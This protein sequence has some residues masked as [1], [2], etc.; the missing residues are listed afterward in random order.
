MWSRYSLPISNLYSLNCFATIVS[1]LNSITFTHPPL[2]LI[3][4]TITISINN[5]SSQD[6]Q[7]A[8]HCASS[9]GH[10][11][12]VKL[13]VDSGAQCDNKDKVS[14][15]PSVVLNHDSSLTISIF[16]HHSLFHV[17]PLPC[18]SCVSYCLLVMAS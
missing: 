5:V 18:R 3:H 6:G 15:E 12:V 1:C 14:T 10:N 9:T 16:R 11:D 2:S 4:I 8:L 13:L 17:L 7:T